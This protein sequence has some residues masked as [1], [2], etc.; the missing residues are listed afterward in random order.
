MAGSLEFRRQ[1]GERI[2]PSL[3]KFEPHF[4]LISAGFDGHESEP[5]QGAGEFETGVKHMKSYPI[6]R[7]PDDLEPWPFV[8]ETSNYKIVR[9]NPQASGRQDLGGPDSKHRLGIWRCTAGAFECTERGDELQTIMTG[10]LRIVQADGSVQVF[11]PGDSF[12]TRKGERIVWDIIEDVTKVFF[13]YDRD[14]E[15]S[16]HSGA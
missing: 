15:A 12:F 7:I 3:A 11:G 9:G 13:T 8:G 2:L 1:I 16:E 10:R 5:P 14:G 6:D 4:I